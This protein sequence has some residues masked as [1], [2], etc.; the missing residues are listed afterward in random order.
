MIILEGKEITDR[1][2]QSPTTNQPNKT[3][4]GV[5]LVKVK[6]EKDEESNGESNG[7]PIGNGSLTNSPAQISTIF[8]LFCII[9]IVSFSE[10]VFVNKMNNEILNENTNVNREF[11][12]VLIFGNDKC[13]NFFN[14]L[15]CWIPS[16]ANKFNNSGVLLSENNILEYIF[17][18]ECEMICQ[19][20]NDNFCN[21]IL[22]MNI[23]NLLYPT[24]APTLA[25]T[26]DSTPQP[27]NT[28]NGNGIGEPSID[29]GSCDD[30]NE[31]EIWDGMC[32]ILI[33][34]S[35]C[36]KFKNVL[37]LVFLVLIFGVFVVLVYVF[38]CLIFV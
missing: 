11:G 35:L 22:F 25:C 18:I 9:G 20:N 37:C 17:G 1:M 30:N 4:F 8:V 26:P 12:N 6:G 31:Y 29:I 28:F 14:G 13:D 3:R 15:F 16:R 5:P 38:V 10:Y 19:M 24:P 34:L 32:D 7:S 2:D 36:K 23:I 21:I 33:F 27:T